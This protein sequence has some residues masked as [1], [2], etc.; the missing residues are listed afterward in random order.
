MLEFRFMDVKFCQNNDQIK[1]IILMMTP[2]IHYVS[3]QNIFPQ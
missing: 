3:K 1:Y 2:V